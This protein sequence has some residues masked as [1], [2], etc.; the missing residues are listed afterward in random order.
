MNDYC[1]EL[2]EFIIKTIPAAMKEPYQYV[3]Y[4]FI[5]PSS[6]YNQNLWDWDAYWSEY[7][8]FTMMDSFPV[9][10]QEKIV[11]HAKGNVLNF[12]DHQLEDGYIPMMMDAKLGEEPYLNQKHKEN[13]PMNMHKPFLCQQI[14]LIS[15]YIKGYQ[16]IRPWL[17]SLE[18]YFHAYDQIHYN[19]R[20]GLYVWVN[21]I[22]I[23]MDNDPTSFGR[24]NNS[25]ANIFLNSFMVMELKAYADLLKQCDLHE[26]AKEIEKKREGLI[27]AIQEECWDPRDQF[28]YSAD[29]DIKTRHF[30]WFHQG[31]GAFWKTLPIKIRTW[32]GFIPML[33]G[34]ATKEQAQMMVK[35]IF[36]EKTF[37]SDYGI[38]SIAK[39][40][41]MFSVCASGNPS[42]WLGGIWT[43]VNYVVYKGLLN[44]GYVNEAKEIKRMTIE[45]L[46]RD[47]KKT[48]M[49]HEYYNPFTGEP[50]V[51]GGFLSWN[52]LAVTMGKER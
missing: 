7:A 27:K 25:T 3:R 49:L 51:N 28:F 2:E 30:D 29:V 18:K 16:W 47:L 23:G 36:D 45:V 35:H 1:K 37:Y 32:S 17:F 43:I 26:E 20:C 11:D 52:M 50:V 46:G 34:F 14:I 40:E 19:H 9:T 44:Y 39:D 24:P 13:I 33:A 31:L 10:L 4:P 42:N 15:G 38:T 21:D 48:G 8:L 22:M 6:V 5:D 41:K 12:L